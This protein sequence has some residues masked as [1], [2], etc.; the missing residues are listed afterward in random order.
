MTKLPQFQAV[1][2]W[3]D[4]NA[5]IKLKRALDRIMVMFFPSLAT[6]CYSGAQKFYR[7]VLLVIMI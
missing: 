1:K 5:E 2:A 4:I 3:Q 7:N 6:P